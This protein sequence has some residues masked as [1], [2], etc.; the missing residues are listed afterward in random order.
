MRW[1]S[2]PVP[3]VMVGLVAVVVLCACANGSTRSG[4]TAGGRTATNTSNHSNKAV[5]PIESAGGTNS[6]HHDESCRP[7]RYEGFASDL[8]CRF[9]S[10]CVGCSC[11]PVDRGEYE[12]RGGPDVCNSPAGEECIAT[13]PACCDGRCV[14]AR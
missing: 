7:E 13:N 8:P 6:R 3:I 2:L 9:D 1:S 12:R 4:S 10:E 14:L 11:R 5:T